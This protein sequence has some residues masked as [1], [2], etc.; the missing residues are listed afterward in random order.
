MQRAAA[1]ARAARRWQRYERAMP[2]SRAFVVVM[3]VLRAQSVL[4]AGKDACARTA[5]HARR[6]R[7]RLCP[8]RQQ[9]SPLFFFLPSINISFHFHYFH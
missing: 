2:R 9:L 5:R 4:D 1:A 8:D 3:P 6:A 7:Q